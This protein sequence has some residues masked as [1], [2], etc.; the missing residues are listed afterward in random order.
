MRAREFGSECI[1]NEHL[2]MGQDGFP[3]LGFSR[4]GGQLAHRLVY[5]LYIGEIPDGMAVSRHCKNKR[6]L[7]PTHLY[8]RSHAEASA[9]TSRRVL[10]PED[11]WYVRRT[12]LSLGQ[13]AVKLNYGKGP[14]CLIRRRRIGQVERFSLRY[15]LLI[16]WEKISGKGRRR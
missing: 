11:F 2:P 5:R 4:I 9:D 8:L 6:C 3:R 10:T 1:V 15:A 14:L 13:L 12:S 7:N 16:I